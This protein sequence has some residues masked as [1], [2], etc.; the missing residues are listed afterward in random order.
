MN[1][2]SLTLALAFCCLPLSVPGAEN[3]GGGKADVT[4]T[5]VSVNRAQLEERDLMASDWKIRLTNNSSRPRWIA[6]VAQKTR[7]AYLLLRNPKQISYQVLE[8]SGGRWTD[9]QMG[10]SM[11]FGPRD[12]WLLLEPGKSFEF[13][14]PILDRFETDPAEVRLS[15]QIA[16]DSDKKKVETLLSETFVHKAQP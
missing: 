1:R 7:E 5:R 15:L 11:L 14:A 8:K 6:T 4:L 9:S 3:P 13:V 16:T 2:R 12:H 10:W